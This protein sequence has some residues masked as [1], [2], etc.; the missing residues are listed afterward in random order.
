MAG[1]CRKER[2]R[3]V[4]SVLKGTGAS[5][6][7]A[8]MRSRTREGERVVMSMFSMVMWPEGEESMRRRRRWRR[9]DLPLEGGGQ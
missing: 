7:M 6:L 9:V 4:R 8:I 2:S 5:W 1:E 3:W